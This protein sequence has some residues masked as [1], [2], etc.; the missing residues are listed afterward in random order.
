MAILPH[1]TEWMSVK[2]SLQILSGCSTSVLLNLA[3]RTFRMNKLNLKRVNLLIFVRYFNL[4]DGTP[5]RNFNSACFHGF[6]N[7]ISHDRCRG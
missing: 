3:D 5:K 1:N 7:V 6:T 2:Y 4:E